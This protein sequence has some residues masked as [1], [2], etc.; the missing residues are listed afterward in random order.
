MSLAEQIPGLCGLWA[1]DGGVPGRSYGAEAVLARGTGCNANELGWLMDGPDPDRWPV[2]VWRRH[3][4]PA[5]AGM[6]G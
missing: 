2:V 6:Y 5:W 1:L 3:D 4:E